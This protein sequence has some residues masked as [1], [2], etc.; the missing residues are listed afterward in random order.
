MTSYV[1]TMNDLNEAMHPL[2]WIQRPWVA[3]SRSVD[4]TEVRKMLVITFFSV[5]GVLRHYIGLKCQSVQN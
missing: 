1:F 3:T 5:S 2:D 4:I